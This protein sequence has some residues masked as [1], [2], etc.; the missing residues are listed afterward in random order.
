VLPSV[1]HAHGLRRVGEGA[2][3]GAS[4][5][6]SAIVG[7]ATGAACAPYA[8]RGGIAASSTVTTDAG[9]QAR[10]ATGS[11]AEAA[12]SVTEALRSGPRS[13]RSMRARA[14]RAAA[15]SPRALRPDRPQRQSDART[16]AIDE[17]ADRQ[18]DRAEQHREQEALVDPV[19][20]HQAEQQSDQLEHR[21]FP[22]LAPIAAQRSHRF[23]QRAGVASRAAIGA[24]ATS[25]MREKTPRP[26]A[27]RGRPPTRE[28]K[29]PHSPCSA[30]G[31]TGAGVRS[32]ISLKPDGSRRARRRA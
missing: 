15:R 29:L 8:G 20:E 6:S 22:R 21:R 16:P 26:C 4:A 32:R 31:T 23:A 18:S 12:T 2:T 10:V 7:V 24:P 17:R 14:R 3:R 19:A 5:G 1:N 28:K 13:A 25:A 9:T 30:I 11:I 27:S